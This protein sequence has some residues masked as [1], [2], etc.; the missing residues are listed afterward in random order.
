MIHRSRN[1]FRLSS[2]EIKIVIVSASKNY[3]HSREADPLRDGEA[4]VL[5]ISFL[6]YDS[7]VRCVA[8]DLERSSSKSLMND[9]MNEEFTFSHFE[10]I[11]ART[12]PN[13]TR[14]A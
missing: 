4:R 13:M 10:H 9:R 8:C 6:R 1:V 2:H 14:R 3:R 5:E 11:C 7:G 12:I